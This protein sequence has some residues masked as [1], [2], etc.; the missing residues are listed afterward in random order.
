M[1]SH[2]NVLSWHAC[3]RQSAGVPGAGNVHRASRDLLLQEKIGPSHPARCAHAG[4]HLCRHRYGAT[5][6]CT[7]LLAVHL[8]LT[9]LAAHVCSTLLSSARPCLPC[10]CASHLSP[11]LH[12]VR[13]YPTLLAV[14]VQF[15]LC[16]YPALLTWHPYPTLDICASTTTQFALEPCLNRAWCVAHS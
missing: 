13:L 3:G 9:P 15:A 16:L 2:A 10:T 8:W 11:A 5:H 12:A 6:L 4:D 7:S 1:H 14:L